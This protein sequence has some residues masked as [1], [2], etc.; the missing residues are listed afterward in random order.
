MVGDVS[1]YYEPP[2]DAGIFAMPQKIFK[3]NHK[4]WKR[5]YN[6]LFFVVTNTRKYN[7]REQL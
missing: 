3:D 6:L 4:R 1:E 7:E 2:Y 5:M